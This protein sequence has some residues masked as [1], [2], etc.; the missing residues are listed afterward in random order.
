[1]AARKEFIIRPGLEAEARD[2]YC[3]ALVMGGRAW[4]SQSQE[5]WSTG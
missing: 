3:D 4:Y 1:M 2:T 5:N